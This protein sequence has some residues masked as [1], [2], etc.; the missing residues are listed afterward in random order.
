[1]KEFAPGIPSKERSHELPEISSPTTWQFG[2]HDHNA[3]RRGRHF[4]LRLG[5]PET[6]DAHSWAMHT[7]W[8]KPGEKTWAIQQPTHTV[9]YM[10]FEGRIPEG[11]GKGDVK[12]FDRDKTEVTSSRPG[13]VSFNIYRSNGPEEYTL[14]RVGDKQWILMN[15]T[16]HR[17]KHPNLPDSKPKYKEIS[18]SKLSYDDPRVIFQPKIDDAHNLFIFPEAGEQIRVVSYRP[19]NRAQGVIEHTHKIPGIY[20]TRVPKDLGGTILR[21][22]LYALDPKTG[23]ATPAEHVGGLLNSDVWKSREK[24]KEHGELLSVLYDVV[25]FHGK[26]MS[27]AP[28]K[29]KLEVLKKVEALLPHAVHLPRIARTVKEK[30]QMVEDIH[31]GRLPETKEGVVVW[32]LEEGTSPIKAKFVKE[33]DV[34]VRDFFPGDGKYKS[35]GVGGFLFSHEPDGPI[36]GRVGTGLSDEQRID[37]YKHPELYK[38]LVAR[39][40]AQQKYSSGALRAPALLGWHLDKNIQTKLDLV[41]HAEGSMVLC[42]MWGESIR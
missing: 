36:V 9:R 5:D 28:Y 10:D 1:V 12:L 40:K 30:K 42:F 22:G 24:Q 32:N 34:Y 23:E 39:V 38:G 15:R 27:N 35:R 16:T 31:A 11:Y 19:T 41:K 7:S 26:D 8:P 33:H 13:H 3:E 18:T 25:R 21:G 17:A 29:E 37:M 20:G 2:V 4:D 14:H 6:G